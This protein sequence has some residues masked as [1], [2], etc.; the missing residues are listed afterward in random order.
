MKNDKNLKSLARKSSSSGA[1]FIGRKLL[2]NRLFPVL[3]SVKFALKAFLPSYEAI[4]DSLNIQTITIPYHFT[5]RSPTNS[6]ISPNRAV[7]I[8]LKTISLQ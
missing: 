7:I 1:L 4:L 6:L 5:D 3:L 2:D 8:I